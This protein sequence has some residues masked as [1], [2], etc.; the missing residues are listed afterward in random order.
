MLGSTEAQTCA[1][2]PFA[3]ETGRLRMSAGLRQQSHADRTTRSLS[4]HVVADISHS[5]TPPLPR[6]FPARPAL[7]HGPSS[8]LFLRFCP[9]D[10]GCRLHPRPALLCLYFPCPRRPWQLDAATGGPLASTQF[11]RLLHSALP[12]RCQSVSCERRGGVLPACA[13]PPREHAWDKTLLPGSKERAHGIREACSL[14]R[15]SWSAL[16]ML[17]APIIQ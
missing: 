16:Y 1:R 13:M 7:A 6:K 17:P 12:P 5:P 14:S 15:L 9:T 4:G 11:V 10:Q 8:S 2:Q 3:A